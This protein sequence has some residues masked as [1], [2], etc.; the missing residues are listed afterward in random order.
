MIVYLKNFIAKVLTSSIISFVVSFLF[1][2]VIP[3]RGLKIDTRSS[4]VSDKTCASIFWRI[5]EGAEIK[6]IRKYLP[7]GFDVIELGS[8]IGVVSSY[9]R[10]KMLESNKLVCVEANQDLIDLISVN[11]MLNSNSDLNVVCNFAINY[12]SPDVDVY[13]ISGTSNT[14]GYITTSEKGSNAQVIQKKTLLEIKNDYFIDQYVLVVDIEGSEIEI[15]MNETEAFSQCR[16]LFIEL[17]VSEYEGVI[18]TIEDMIYLLTERH[19]FVLK[20][21]NDNVCYFTK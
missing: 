4:F 12:S 8:S 20:D 16:H 1:G 19:N 9:L 18:Y 7:K 15:I 10:S 11:L 17:H 2:K 3:F 6:F 5:Y 21:R 14:T 13:F